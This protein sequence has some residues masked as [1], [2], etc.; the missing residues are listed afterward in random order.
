MQTIS[1]H[2]QLTVY[3]EKPLNAGTPLDLLRR[4]FF[5]PQ[6]H[7]YLRSHGTIPLITKASYRLAVG[8]MAQRRLEFTC[9]ELQTRFTEHTVAAT[10]VCAG[11][12]RNELAAV[13]PIPDEILWGADPIGT[14][15]WRGARL[16]DVLQ[17]AGIGSDTRYVAFTGLDQAWIAGAWAHF[18]ASLALDKA[19]S[20]DV[21]LAYA[22]NDTPLTPEHGAPVRLV[23]P[24]YIGARSVKWLQ[25]I[26][27]QDHPSTN[28]FQALDYKTFPPDIRENTA[29]WEHG[30]T[31]E[32]LDLNAVMC[33]P[34][35]GETLM[36]GPN[37]I[38]GYAIGGQG[39][40]VARVE[41]SLDQG[42]TW[43]QASIVERADPW[44][45]CFWEA[46]LNLPPGTCQITVRAWD[47]SGQTQPEQV[48]PLW[49]F[50]G[51]V[52]TAWQHVHVYVH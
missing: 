46:T 49:N 28:P 10:L 23:V 37:K 19:L 30:K 27:L 9:E 2:Q 7:F 16:R 15:I 29:N 33:M 36:A 32:E 47:V 17:A 21:L 40:P 38:Q 41:L 8:G 43:Q 51:Y 50:K 20:P 25:E 44:A 18:G 3:R 6:E 31:L 24:G 34:Q 1:P 35:E 14:A 45:W 5:T 39:G 22:L 48:E 11:S 4:A 26:T 12:R 52:N 42:A 13:R